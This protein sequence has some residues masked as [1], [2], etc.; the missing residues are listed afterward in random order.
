MVKKTNKEMS[1]PKTVKNS[2][3]NSF[4]DKK[5]R[6]IIDIIQRTYLSLSFCKHFDIFSKSSIGQ[7]S[8]H[9]QTIY[10]TAKKLKDTVPIE[11]KEMDN[12]LNIV[13]SIFDKLSI[14]FSTYGTYSTN[15]VYYVVFGTK[16]N[17]FDTYDEQNNYNKDKIDLIEKYILPIGYKNLPWSECNHDELETNKIVDV[18]LQIDKYA[19]LE[20]FEPTTMY[21][22]IH[23]SVY[24]VRI[25]IRNTND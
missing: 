10:D 18:T 13:Q 22:S 11:D 17:K 8:D 2:E 6:Q 15:D 19:H 1:V 23:Q 5:L 20:C 25:L 9:L 4:I 3:F 21:S 16:Y 14:V 24:G 7:C 12:T